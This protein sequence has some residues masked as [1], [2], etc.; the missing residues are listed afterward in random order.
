MLIDVPRKSDGRSDIAELQLRLSTIESYLATL[1][2][3]NPAPFMTLNSPRTILPAVSLPPPLQRASSNR[4]TGLFVGSSITSGR[5]SER[6]RD[7]EENFSDVDVEDAAVNLENGVFGN[8][9]N[10]GTKLQMREESADIGNSGR[11]E[12]TT[13]GTSIIAAKQTFDSSTRSLAHLGI[14]FSASP[15]EI[16]AA[17]YAAITRILHLIVPHRKIILSFVNTYF[18]PDRLFSTL[19]EPTFRTE[20]EFFFQLCDS[21]RSNEVDPLW[22][23][24]L[25][26]VCSFPSSHP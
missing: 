19:H 20:L 2:L 11:M 21:G 10:G 14:D 4:T 7:H 9:L 1:S 5:T 18:G 16:R 12:L 13:A 3:P 6:G 15:I 17:Y 8:G 24:L 26:M 23:S 25:C 22:L